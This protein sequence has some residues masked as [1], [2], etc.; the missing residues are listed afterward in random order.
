MPD[1]LTLSLNQRLIQQTLSDRTRV[2]EIADPAFTTNNVGNAL[3]GLLQNRLSAES[4]LVAQG[5]ANARQATTVLP[6]VSDALD[7]IDLALTELD[8]LA[9]AAS[10]DTATDTERAFLNITFKAT[11]DRINDIAERT[12]EDSVNV[13]AGTNTFSATNHGDD[14]EAADGFTA[15]N[16]DSVATGNL[17]S[18]DTFTLDFNSTTNEFTLTNTTTGRMERVNAPATAPGTGEIEN[19]FFIDFGITA[20]VNENFNTAADIDSSGGRAGFDV[21][22]VMSARGFDVQ[23]GTETET[24]DTVAVSLEPAFTGSLA[25]PLRTAEITNIANA[26]SAVSGIDSAQSALAE[27]RGYVA[28]IRQQLGDV[29]FESARAEGVL[30][31]SAGSMLRQANQ[32]RELF[33]ILSDLALNYV[34][35][36]LTDP[37]RN[38]ITSADSFQIVAQ[39]SAAASSLAL[40]AVDVSA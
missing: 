33:K 22:G 4:I 9:S 24:G 12:E 8:T 31:D 37:F 32:R 1:F 26:T 5:G 11:L 38:Q 19:I 36:G 34:M 25:T 39:Q 40:A 7:L 3:N 16:F 20:V 18:G 15:F 10:K 13:L 21:A 27:R 30:R 28:G 35:P 14:L 29:S 2:P 6:N 17:E 23:V